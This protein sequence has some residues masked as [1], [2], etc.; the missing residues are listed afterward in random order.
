MVNLQGVAPGW[1][2][3]A[4]LP[5]LLGRDVSLVD[6]AGTAAVPVVIGNDFARAMWG[7]ANPIGRT[8]G[9]PQLHGMN[10]AAMVLTIVGVYD[11]S[12]GIPKLT[13][14]GGGLN[15]KGE[16]RVYTARG[17]R[18]RSDLLLVRTRGAG[19]PL[20]NDLR[21]FIRA[22]APTLPIESIRTL[23][24]FEAQQDQMSV[25][26]AS[27]T[28]VAA[29]VALLLT[30]LGLYGVVALAVQQR[31]RE[32]GIRIAIG[33][34]PAAVT[35]MFLRSGV[36]IAVIALLIG[37][38]VTV[39]GLQFGQ[40]QGVVNQGPNFLLVGLGV[41]VVLLAVAGAATWR[42]ARRAARVHPAIALRGE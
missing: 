16:F 2:S 14:S 25:Q 15:P 42:P 21:Q 33:A 8:L 19:A 20:V 9:A 10:D 28:G 36:R 40:M 34:N 6:T 31:T 22:E 39:A 24:E 38:P 23:A 37:L 27:L 4:E 17:K 18:W 13:G 1:L 12:R 3:I 26:E 5:I 7:N 30:S 41:S 35:R 11:A 29:L 32:I